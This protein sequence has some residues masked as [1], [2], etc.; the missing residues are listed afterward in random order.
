MKA[1]ERV[2]QYYNE[3]F[4]NYVK[5]VN[6]YYTDFYQNLSL[7]Y[8]RWLKS[9]EIANFE[10]LRELFLLEQYLNCMPVYV[11]N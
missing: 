10:D 3:K 5:L 6:D 8:E 11:K 9:L 4:R 2:P 1:Y 7:M